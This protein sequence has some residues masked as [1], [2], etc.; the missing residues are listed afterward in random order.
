MLFR[1]ANAVGY[2]SYPDNVVREFVAESVRCG[3]DIFRIF[4]SLNYVDN[5]KFG[6]DAV[7]DAGGVVEATLCYT[8]DL[9]DPMRSKVRAGAGVGGLGV[10]GGGRG[11]PRVGHLGVRQQCEVLLGGAVRAFKLH[12]QGVTLA[13]LAQ[14]SNP[15]LGQ[16]NHRAGGDVVA[17]A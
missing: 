2:T 5:L 7:R 4:D 8:G 6:M 15:Q 9:S 1:G 11:E 17:W 12:W 13:G 3:V 16:G 14:H 10:E